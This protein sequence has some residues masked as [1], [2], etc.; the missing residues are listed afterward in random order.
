LCRLIARLD[1]PLSIGELPAWED[2]IR[3][4]HNHAFRHV[5]RQTTTRDLEAL[6]YVKQS[7][8]KELLNT[9][10]CVCLT[11]DIWFGNVEDYL[12]VVFHFVTED[13]ELEKHVVGTRLI[14]CSHTGISIVECIMQVISEY[15][16]SSKVFSITLDNASTNAC[17]MTELVPHLVSYVTCS[18]IAAGLMHQRCAC[19]IINLIVK[20]GLKHIKDQL[21]DFRRAISWLNYSNQCIASFKSVCIAHGVRP[22]KFGLD[23]DARWNSTYLLLKHLVPYKNT[24][25][26]VLIIR[27]EENLC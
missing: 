15:S 20:S 24:Y 3:I 21:E 16:M 22:H 18:L 10:S 25:L 12:G 8:V 27:L 5:S 1:L 13:W 26:L 7:D 6:F 19:H 14:D 2:Y 11:S 9:A 23:M 4:A 17:A